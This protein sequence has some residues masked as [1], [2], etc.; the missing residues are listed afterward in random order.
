M[1]IALVQSA[2][3]TATTGSSVTVTLGS[4]TTLGH[5]LVVCVG[6]A[7]SSSVTVSGIKIGGSADNF[8]LAKALTDTPTRDTD[9]EVWTDQDIGESSTSVIVTLSG[10]ISNGV[11][12]YVMEFSGVLS[13]LAVDKTNAGNATTTFSSG[14]SGTLSSSN[15]VVIGAVIAY[16]SSGTPTIGGPS[17]PWTNL[18]QINA[19]GLS[20]LSLVA[21]YEVV[22]ATTAQTYS[23]TSTGA[24]QSTAIIVTLEGLS[25]VTLSPAAATVAIATPQQAVS[26]SIPVSVATV[27]I[28]TPQP[29]VLVGRYSPR[30]LRQSVSLCRNRR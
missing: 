7:S 9:A 19:S 6:T 30:L 26:T 2:S 13:S 27:T 1:A 10:S 15:E 16:K 22:S 5:C 4:A 18:T 14:S 12:V 20:T 25:N 23:G 24:N 3:N 29:S 11:V 8:A 21:S 17:S 28:A